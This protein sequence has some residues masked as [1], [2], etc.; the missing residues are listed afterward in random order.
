[1]AHLPVLSG[2]PSA[3]YRVD[4]APGAR[5]GCHSPRNPAANDFLASTGSV[6][7]RLRKRAPAPRQRHRLLRAPAIDYSLSARWQSTVFADRSTNLGVCSVDHRVDLGPRRSERV[8]GRGLIGSGSLLTPPS[9]RR[10]C[11]FRALYRKPGQQLGGM[12]H[13]QGRR[14]SER[15]EAQANEAEVL[16]GA[17]ATSWWPPRWSAAR[18]RCRERRDERRRRGAQMPRE[19]ASN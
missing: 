18:C 2:K 9:E 13:G 11:A 4:Q 6:Q 15:E 17:A 19:G 14:E 7:G 3:A 10:T 8:F 5:R 12:S 16:C 1:M